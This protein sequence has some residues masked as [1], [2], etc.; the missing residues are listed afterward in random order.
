M[1]LR[2]IGF[3]AAL[4]LTILGGKAEASVLI[5]IFQTGGDVVAAGG[6]SID[7]TGLQFEGSAIVGATGALWPS[8][9]S[10]ITGTNVFV[11]LYS[12]VSGPGPFGPGG[13][14]GGSNGSGDAFGLFQGDV[15]VPQ[16]YMSGSPL[17][18]S[19]TFV[20]ETFKSLGL[21]PGT[22]VYTWN[23]SPVPAAFQDDS[24]TVN[25]APIPEPAT[26]AMMALGFIGLGVAGYRASRKSAT[27]AA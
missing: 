1:K 17:I 20:G 11:D 10:V 2:N 16:G 3:A 13:L 12:S 21:T 4:G 24:L 5:N 27:L 8:M 26:W 14:I 18:G 22:Y 9:A 23:S 6:G 25:I 15:V 19:V 7:L